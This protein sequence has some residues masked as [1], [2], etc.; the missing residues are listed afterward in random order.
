MALLSGIFNTS[1]TFGSN[2]AELNA[3][4]FAGTILRLFPNGSAPLF[5][6]SSQSGKSK[7]KSSTH[8]YFSKTLSFIK[9]TANDTSSTGTLVLAASGTVGMTPGMVLANLRSKENYLVI[10]ITNG[11]TAVVTRGFGRTVATANIVGDNIIQI[12]TAFAENSNRPTARSISTTYV[13]N[14][15]QIFRNSWGLSDTARASMAE[16]GFSNVAE[17]R[18]DCSLFHSTDIEAA[19]L[20]GQ[21]KM[22]V[23]GSMPIHATQ[24]IIDAVT[25][26]SVANVN[27]AASTTSFNQLVALVEPAFR[28]STDMSNP[29]SRAGFCDSIGMRV[30]H[31]IAKLS[32][33]IEIMQSETS[34]GMQFTKFK[35]YKGEINL[36][37]HPLLNGLAPNAATTGQM[38]I[39]DLP[40]LK[41]AY[42]EG[43][44]T[45]A[46]EYNVN[47]TK[48]ENGI[49]GV[50]GSLT[51]E[52]AVE[53][54]NPFSC[55]VITNLTAGVA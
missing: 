43:R 20:Y 14:Y 32:G 13:P 10:S 2:P 38:I 27:A 41:L 22:D 30:M 50:G 11:T 39:V 48:V 53:L 44:D 42:M 18:K 12:G 28:F 25:Q 45:I 36:I 5:A 24:G 37:E 19:I 16:Q 55:A 54:I 9:T 7:A 31:Q 6:L 3:R 47:G 1:T 51:S 4:S 34:F 21:P 52:L 26:Y 15:T 17:N 8:G 49:D 23:T 35:F 40:A 46:E 29:K 33:Q